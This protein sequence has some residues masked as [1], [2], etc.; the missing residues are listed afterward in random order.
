MAKNNS[1]G[2]RVLL[3][4][5]ALE[6]TASYALARHFGSDPASN[7]PEDQALAQHSE[8]LRGNKNRPNQ[9]WLKCT[10]WGIPSTGEADVKFWHD[11]SRLEI[12]ARI[13][14][15]LTEAYICTARIL[16]DA[17]SGRLSIDHIDIDHVPL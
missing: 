17:N 6:L 3:G 11:N 15:G 4:T 7:K 8:W 14:L 2:T 10:F 9:L 13:V 5:R 1:A 12:R 16:V